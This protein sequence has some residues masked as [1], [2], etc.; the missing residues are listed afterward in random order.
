MPPDDE[1]RLNEEMG[2]TTLAARRWKLEKRSAKLVVELRGQL[3]RDQG[4]DDANGIK[5]QAGLGDWL[6]FPWEAN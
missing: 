5:F 3:V 2:T 6:P 4:K 1:S